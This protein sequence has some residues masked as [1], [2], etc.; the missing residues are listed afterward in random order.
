MTTV[1]PNRRGTPGPRVD[2]PEAPQ[3]H[4]PQELSSGEFSR[5]MA[6][7]RA[8]TGIA[9][10]Q[11][12]KSM[13]QARLQKR[14]RALS[15]RSFAEYCAYLFSPE[16]IERELGPFINVVTTNKTD[17][18]REPHHF[19]YLARVALPWVETHGMLHHRPVRVWS[20]ACSSGQEPYTLAMVLADYEEHHPGFHWTVL[21]TDIST[22]VLETAVRATY[23][24]E[25]IGPIP[26]AFRKNYLLRGMRSSEGLI[27]INARLRSTV[28]FRRLNFMD[29]RYDVGDPFDIIF[30]R[31]AIIYFDRATQ[32]LI[33]KR[34]T[35][36]LAPGGFLFLGHSESL[37]GIPL[38]YDS[39]ATTV[40]QKRRSEP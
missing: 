35:A 38:P 9:L 3:W 5:L 10:S 14:L 11:V 25:T 6:F 18:F 19:D 12:K 39:V 17:F 26:T 16:G 13:L 36:H 15:M 37:N 30:C 28:E 22:K 27:R 23:R 1:P 4:D 40:Y 24:E 34:L 20:A 8:H 32:S 21:G 29:E 31:N 33:L 2:E 7:I